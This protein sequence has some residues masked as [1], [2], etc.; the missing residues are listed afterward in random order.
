MDE[1]DKQLKALNPE[2]LLAVKQTEGPVL[3]IA[4]PGT[5]KTQLLST[6]AAYILQNTDAKP[7]NI[8][9]LTYTESG[10]FAMR[11]RLVNIIGQKAYNITISTYHGFG[12]ELISRFPEH[13]SDSNDLVAVDDLGINAI[14]S[15]II[16]EL[17]YDDP[18]KKSDFYIKDVISAIGDFKK[19]LLKPDDIQ[20]IVKSN[21]DFIDKT[22]DITRDVLSS[23][24]RIDK[25][26]I[27]AFRS[28]H[29]KTKSIDETKKLPSSS[30]L[31]KLWKIELREAIENAEELNITSPLTE[32][33]N[34]W[35]ERDEDGLF[36]VAGN[37]SADKLSSLAGIYRKYLDE[38]E[39]QGLFDYD[40]MILRAIN[41]LKTNKAL[42]FTLQ[43]QY[44]YVMLDEFQ[45]T[46][47]AQLELIKLLTDSPIYE[48]TPNVLAVGD[49]DQAIYSF[50]GADYS[51]MSTFK[52]LYKNTRVICLT[53]NYRSHA[54]V[55][56]TAHNI[57]SQIETRLHNDMAD[58]NKVL[59]AES[60][61]LPKD[62]LVQRH[63]FKSDIA[64]FAWVTK[65]IQSLIKSGVNP[66]EIA[67]LAPKHKFLEPILPYLAKAKIPVRYEKREDILS[68]PKIV[69]IIKMSQL[70]MAIRDN[71][72]DIASSL[73]P[74]VLS[75]DFWQIDTEDIWR[76]SWQASDSRQAWTPL[77]IESPKFKTIGLFFVQLANIC[78]I[79][80]LE[81]VLDY[82]TGNATLSLN[83]TD[84]KIYVSP[85]FEYNFGAQAKTDNRQD[86][87]DLL[88]NL[89]V[90]RQHLRDH[91]GVNKRQL[92]L[93]DLIDFVNKHISAE[94]K[95]L[96][97]SPYHEQS[98]SVQIMSAYKSKGLEFEAVFMLACIDEVWGSKARSQSSK[99]PLPKN[100]SHIR[101]S[102]ATDDEKLRLLFVAMTRAKHQLYLTSYVSNYSNRPTTRVKYFNEIETSDEVVS[103]ILPTTKQNIRRTNAEEPTIEDLS[104]Y[105]A[106]THQKL[107]HNLHFKDLLTPRLE[108]FQLSPTNLN[109]F[110]DLE[111]GGP[112]YFFTNTLLMFPSAPTS[113]GEFGNVIHEVIE[114]IH[115][116][117]VNSKKLPSMDKILD[118]FKSTLSQKNISN[119]DHQLLIK[120]GEKCLR[121]Y[122]SQKLAEFTPTDLH[123]FNFK[124]EG[125][126]VGPAHLTGK[127][128]KMIIDKENRTISIVDFKTGKSYNNWKS[129]EIKLHKY[130]Q[131][132]YLYK[133]LV[134]GSYTFAE[135]KV[136][137]AYLQFV[138][139]NDKGKIVD[140]HVDFDST[141][142]KHTRDLAIA[143]WKHI[144]AL[145][146][147]DVD[148][149]DKS[150]KGVLEFETDLIKN[151]P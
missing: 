48:G 135:Y 57:S 142:L 140:L 139:P 126:L 9:C 102:G 117:Q 106:D 31:A 124:N 76:L 79:E 128:D 7:H 29:E 84:V 18:L 83:N 89:T 43:E 127:I 52:Q 82:L 32:W 125:V 71:N 132:L 90:L 34:N 131:Q 38:L 101:Y 26:S 67:I 69:Q 100:L 40:D 46:N 103:K 50:Q 51:H 36:V 122:L 68:D 97:T 15:Q 13:F 25:K 99:I 141:E 81:S 16:A 118:R 87:W 24:K 134:E 91:R 138:E 88:S 30:S 77:I 74:E 80:T 119:T 146:L 144:H 72:M 45:D 10:E 96:N 60:K 136:N 41:G 92:Y 63:E 121:A 1:Y 145:S 98:D 11:Q 4:G 94:I 62:A 8:L 143:V 64:Q 58:V 37:N 149:Y 109:A 78:A 20:K 147:P 6:R 104:S 70:V 111:Y 105:W 3:V 114:W 108:R 65:Q 75:Y 86:F 61:N 123:E 39:R 107:A 14:I 21:V 22:S 110:T 66:K 55:L 137:D 93:T 59:T 23:V 54:D 151:S 115:I 133:L 2:Q 47:G 150:L 28:L 85:Y 17:P 130:K 49:D 129:N 19:A 27:S 113:A 35:L 148:K 44:L 73:W 116:Q 33:K 53:K 95:I 120:R 12:R 112:N 56:E 5:G 42:R